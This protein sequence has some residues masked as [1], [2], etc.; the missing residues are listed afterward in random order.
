MIELKEYFA[1]FIKMFKKSNICLAL[2]YAFNIKNK[3]YSEKVIHLLSDDV[4]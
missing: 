2:M 1:S 4:L 3:S